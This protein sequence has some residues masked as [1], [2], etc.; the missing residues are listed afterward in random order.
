MFSG[1]QLRRRIVINADTAER[2]GSVY[3]AEI[4]AVTGQVTRLVVRRYG[5]L[6]A[7][8]KIGETLIPWS[9][10]VAAG[11]EYILVKKI[12]FGEKCLKNP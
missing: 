2:V 9:A 11:S 12:D 5:G 7:F 3:D 1:N 6:A 8:F 4:D 10:I